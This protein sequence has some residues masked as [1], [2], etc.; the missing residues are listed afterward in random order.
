LTTAVVT[1]ANT[2]LGYA[3][4]RALA[5]RGHEVVLAC[6]DRD[7]GAAALERLRRELPGATARLEPLDLADLGSVETF[8]G[9][10]AGEV[11]GVDVLVNNAGVMALPV[12]KVT[13][14][15]FEAQ[16]GTNHLG[17]FALTGR[18]LSRLL[19]RPAARV[20]TVASLA[21][22]GGE[23]HF[24]DL[25]LER[26][27]GGQLAYGQSKLAN[28]L[29]AFELDRRA[30]AAGTSLVSVGV[31]PGVAS[32]ELGRGM[33]EGA[34]PLRRAFVKA[35]RALSPLVLPSAR[36]GAESQIHAALED[37]V[38]GGE[39]WGPVRGWRGRPQVVAPPPAALDAAAAGHL[40]ALSEELTGVRYQFE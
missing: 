5:E 39:Y 8:A 9:R 34:G 24:D 23:L 21:A 14:D 18:L 11:D 33:V 32:T 25:Q 30:R 1:G 29:F 27:Y 37:D 36:A 19:A 13:V 15:G 28:I 31:H 3:T 16:L 35:S 38:E 26:S 4:A 20:V 6:R 7:R 40:W 22:R 2:G 10:L 12:R 17:H